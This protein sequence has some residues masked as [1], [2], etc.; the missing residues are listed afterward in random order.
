[1]KVRRTLLV[2]ARVIA[3]LALFLAVTGCGDENED[4]DPQTEVSGNQPICE[5]ARAR[6]SAQCRGKAV[7]TFESACASHDKCRAGCVYD[8]PCDASA[9]SACFD[10]RCR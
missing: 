10:A 7:P 8:N 1:M 5:E 9:Q 4:A 6:V 2:R 3:W